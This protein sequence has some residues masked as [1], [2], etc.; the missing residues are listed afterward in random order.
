MRENKLKISY[1]YILNP[2][3]ID[4]RK[5]NHDLLIQKRRYNFVT[6]AH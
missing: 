3:G 5:Y 4:L 1:D 2:I 6:I